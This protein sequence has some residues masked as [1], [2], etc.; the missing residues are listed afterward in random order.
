[1]I[2]FLRTGYNPRVYR[3]R[4]S[5]VF[6]VS[7]YPQDSWNILQF[8]PG[9][10]SYRHFEYREDSGTEVVAVNSFLTGECCVSLKYIIRK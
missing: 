7:K 10:I 4:K 5:R 9:T 3:K 8:V 1:M 2:K 6:Y